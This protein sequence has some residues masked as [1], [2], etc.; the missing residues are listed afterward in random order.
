MFDVNE[1]A[2]FFVNPDGSYGSSFSVPEGSKEISK[3]E[4]DSFLE[5]TKK[6]EHEAY[7]LIKAMMD[8]TPE[9]LARL[10]INAENSFSKEELS[11]FGIGFVNLHTNNEQN[12]KGDKK[13]YAL[14]DSSRTRHEGEPLMTK[15]QAV[16]AGYEIG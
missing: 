10:M 13:W 11:T 1:N 5:K 14:S 4:Y 12:S 15:A 7:V 16:A 9:V 8:A 6:E 2:K 3:D